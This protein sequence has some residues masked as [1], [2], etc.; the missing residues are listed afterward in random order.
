[1]LSP[2]PLP[3]GALF[4]SSRIYHFRGASWLQDF[5]TEQL[6]FPASEHDDQV[7]ALAYAACE[8][9]SFQT[10]EYRP[11]PY[12]VPCPLTAGLLAKELDLGPA[13]FKD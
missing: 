2:A 8:L 13:Q 9:P 12:E 4:K 11:R 5:E 7:D 3:S 10:A 6:A 1:V